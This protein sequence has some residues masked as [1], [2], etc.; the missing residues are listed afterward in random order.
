T[1]PSKIASGAGSIVDHRAYD[2][3]SLREDGK[4]AGPG[5]YKLDSYGEDKAVFSANPHYKGTVTTK[6]SGVTLKFYRGDQ[7]A[8]QKAVQAGVV[9]IAC[10]RLTANPIADL[11]ETS[12]GAEDAEL[13]AGCSPRDRRL[14]FDRGAA[15]DGTARVRERVAHL[16]VRRAR[17]PVP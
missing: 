16:R 2:A 4:A 10:R 9:D 1:F 13:G 5:P 7:G 11:G 3:D 17:G 8:L 15:G 14:L 12:Q 6:H